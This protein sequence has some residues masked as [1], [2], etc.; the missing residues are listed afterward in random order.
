MTYTFSEQLDKLSS[1]LGDSNTTTDDAWPIAQRKK[2]INRGEVQFAVDSGDLREYATGTVAS[3]EISVPSDWVKTFMFIVDDVVISNDREIA[4]SDWE[5]YHDW[6]GDDPFYYFW[7]FSGTKKIKLLGNV[8]GSTYFLY[9]FK[10]PTTEL[11]ATT[12]VSIHPE[13]FREASVYYAAAELMKQIGKHQESSLFRN[14]YDQLVNRATV[15]NE[16]TIINKEYARPDFGDDGGS[17]TDIQGR[18]HY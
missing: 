3:N 13:E 5:R 10:K 17:S 15:I 16:K 11:N 4:L 18:G 8:N 7:E 12:D 6:G 9:Y 14:E 2:E 1:L